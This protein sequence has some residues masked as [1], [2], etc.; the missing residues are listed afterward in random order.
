MLRVNTKRLG[1][2]A[3]LCVQGRIVRGDTDA[4]QKAVLC[5]QEASV[6]VLDLRSVR[7]IDAGGLGVLL[8]LRQHAESLGIEFR[9]QHA[10]KLITHILKITRLDTVFEG[11]IPYDL[12]LT[13]HH[14]PSMTFAACA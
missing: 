13:R 12:S 7:M 1:N 9:L 8:G 11:A 6:I 3:V 5:E 4:L 2:I 10:T 14:P